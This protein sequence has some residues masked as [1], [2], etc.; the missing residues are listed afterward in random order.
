MLDVAL[1][2]FLAQRGRFEQT[3]I[4]TA[5]SEEALDQT[6]GFALQGVLTA[7]GP[8]SGQSHA[9]RNLTQLNCLSTK[10]AFCW[11]ALFPS[12]YSQK[13]LDA[14]SE[15][16]CSDGWYAGQYE[17]TGRPNRALSLNTN[18]VVLEALHYQVFGPLFPAA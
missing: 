8:F 11:Q 10:S 2:L 5:L 15:L 17:A 4:L 16:S 12:P 13:L 9:G 3:G 6:P 7:D 1:A 14:V 18:A